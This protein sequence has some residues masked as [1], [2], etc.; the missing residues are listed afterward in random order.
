[1]TLQEIAQEML[2]DISKYTEVR[3]TQIPQVVQARKHKKRRINKKW[4]KRY[5]TKVV[6]KTIRARVADI[7]VNNVIEFC[8]EKGLPIP[9]E[10]LQNR[11]E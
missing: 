7:T 4:K 11:G 10:F 1:M 3:E 6:Y 9:E 8:I 2:K 5:G